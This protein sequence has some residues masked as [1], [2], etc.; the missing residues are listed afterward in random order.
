LL[1]AL[2]EGVVII[3][4]SGTILFVNSRAEQMFG[5]SE[6]ELIGQSHAVLV[7]E[8]FR[9]IHEEQQVHFFA[10]S[11]TRPMGLLLNLTGRRRDGSEFPVEISLGLIE[12]KDGVLVMALVSDMTLRK[13]FETSLQESE[14]LFHI[15]V[16]YVK[17]YSIFMFNTQG[18]ILNWNSGAGRLN[19]YRAEEIIGKH[20]SCFYPEEDRNVGKPEEQLKMAQKQ[21]RVAYEGWRIRKDGSRFWADVI[22]TALYDESGNL[23]GFSIVTHDITERKK[24]EEALRDSETL[25]RN[26]ADTA[27]VLIWMSDTNSLCTFFNKTWLE[28]TGRS[29]EQEQGNGWT[30]GVYPDDLPRGLDTYLSAFNARSNF[31]MEYR[32]RRADGEYRWIFDTGVPRFAPNGDFA[33]YI[34]SCFDI[35]ERKQA[36]EA[37]RKSELQLSKIFHAV[38]VIIGI[39][40]LA[41][42]R[43]I[44]INETGL[45]TLGYRREEM[46]G[47]T[48]LELGIWESKSARDRVIQA[49]EEEGMV[50]DLETNLRGKNGLTF[51]GLFSAER[52]KF[53]GEPYMLSII[54][55]I[56]ERKR[57]EEEIER[58]NVTLAARAAELEAANRELDSFTHTVAHDLRK[59]LT[60]VNG[61]CQALLEL[62]SDKLDEEC[63]GYVQEAYDGTWRMNRLIEVLL[64]FSHLAHIEPS[65]ERVDL[66]AMAHE[67]A[68]E[69]QLAEPE[70]RVTF[71]IAD[72]VSADGDAGLL[73]VVLDNLIGNAW[74]YTGTLE[75]GIIEFG[76]TDINE[77]PVYSVRD[78]GTGFN[79]ADAGKLFVPFQRL[80]GAEEFRG[81]GIGL[82]TVER[83]VR[84]HG[85]RVWAE[86]ELGKG[87]CFYFTLSGARNI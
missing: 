47:R 6:H 56:T 70:R 83:I 46:I 17:D 19:G 57:M 42:G 11:E 4:S 13:Q 34:G 67:V 7:P 33:G 41:E 49:L 25:F 51:T 36:E 29:F 55:D 26:M 76:T 2:A 38:P 62:C 35:T 40:T 20:F 60:V 39:T 31:Q 63:K 86:G 80:P 5:Y 22:I 77:K 16:E 1:E 30:E 54:K 27:P 44:D 14:E 24:A 3:D 58:L 84:C 32:L 72:G 37:L 52:I 48:M 64:N 69:L 59:P 15:Q 66:S 79:M 71:L 50:R 9:K 85:G 75:E 73:R 53:N 68:A 78:N 28:F 87:A 10:E 18:N 43:C 8:R 81:F 23:R 65:R 74:K 45:R 21:G 61:Y 12:T 82:A